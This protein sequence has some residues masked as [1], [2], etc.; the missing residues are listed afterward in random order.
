MSDYY[1]ILGVAQDTSAEDIKKAYRRL[2]AKHHPDRGGDTATFQEIQQA[3][4]TLS[5]PARRQQYDLQKSGQGNPNMQFHWHGN[6][7]MPGN[8]D[9]IFR[10]FGFAG[11]FGDP[12]AAF[13]QQQQRRN[14]DLRIKIILPL[15]ET[16]TDQS[17]TI[18]IQT[19]RGQRET[20]EVKIPRGVNNETTIKYP[21]LGGDMF[22]SIPRGDLYVHFELRISPDY[23]VDGIDLLTSVKLNCLLAVVGTKVELKTVDGRQFSLSIPPGTQP[24]TRFRIAQQGLYQINSDNRGDLYVDL[25]LTVPLLDEA[26]REIIRNITTGPNT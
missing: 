2:A 5:D 10:Q 22:E 12:F 15:E 23:K 7:P 20:V 18:S 3:Y 13:R 21:G 14:K 26:E 8:I 17:K 9:D 11:G 1:S 4:D 19:D 6:G 16:F 24:N 25:V